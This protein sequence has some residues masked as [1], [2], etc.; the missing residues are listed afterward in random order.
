VNG[1]IAEAGRVD[2]VVEIVLKGV[3]AGV[4]D[5]DTGVLQ[6]YPQAVLGVFS[7]SVYDITGDAFLIAGNVFEMPEGP[8]GS[9]VIHSVQPSA[10]CAEPQA[11][12]A[13]FVYVEQ[14]VVAE[15]G[16][17]VLAVGEM[18]K[19]SGLFV[20]QVQ[21][22]AVG[23]QPDILFAVDEYIADVVAAE[24][25]GVSVAVGVLIAPVA[26][27]QEVDDALVFGTDPEVAGI[28]FGQAGD[29]VTG[30]AGG[31]GVF[32]EGGELIRGAVVAVKS[33]ATGADPDIAVVV[34]YDVGDKVVAE[35]AFVP[36]FVAVDGDLVTV[37]PVEAVA[38]AEPYEAATILE[39]VEHI[40]LGETV[41]DVQMFEFKSRQLCR[42]GTAQADRQQG[43]QKHGFNGWHASRFQGLCTV[44]IRGKRE[45]PGGILPG[46]RF[47]KCLGVYP[48]ANCL[49]G[50]GYGFLRG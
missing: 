24:A 46:W 48:Y 23:A 49:I 40:V 8:L 18:D 28:V 17:V 27:G 4:V 21:A 10:V 11:M 41:I 44:V 39:D 13:V 22:V 7:H 16:W 47:L 3:V 30:E 32:S 50:A 34:F 5:I 43:R 36:R 20:E 45:G 14:F 29:D 26:I 37:V 35:A 19:G 9:R 33:S 2:V 12:A 42:G 25:G 6:S 15:G 31:A 38:G 1:V